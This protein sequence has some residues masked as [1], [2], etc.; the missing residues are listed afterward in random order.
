[1]RRIICRLRC[2]PVF[3]ARKF[4]PRSIRDKKFENGRIRFVVA[5][6]IGRAS[7]SD[8]V[9]MD[10]LRAAVAELE[11]IVMPYLVFLKYAS[12]PSTTLSAYSR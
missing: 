3:R 11:Q 4:P 2:R 10:D 7:L 8:D 1:M 12:T 9:T 6:D 5:H